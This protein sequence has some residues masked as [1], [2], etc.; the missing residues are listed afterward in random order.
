MIKHPTPVKQLLKETEQG[1]RISEF[2]KTKLA[3]KNI[4]MADK[5]KVIIFGNF[6]EVLV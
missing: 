5:N 3:N 1:T 4:S 2:S 6:G